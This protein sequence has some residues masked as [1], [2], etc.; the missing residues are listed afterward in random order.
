MTGELRQ[1]TKTVLERGF[2]M[3]LGIVDE[4]D[5]WVAD[6]IYIFDEDLNLYWMSTT[7]RR[8]SRAIDG[9]YDRVA[10]AI[11]VTQGSDQPDEGLQIS[12]VAKRVDDPSVELLKQW[13]K[14]KGKDYTPDMGAVLEEHVWYQLIPDHIELIY[15]EKFGYNRQKVL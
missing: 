9:G 13:M 4:Q 6:V 15:Q 11:A 7:E 12:G 2:L 5:P 3:S 10:A 1:I 8:H 14:K